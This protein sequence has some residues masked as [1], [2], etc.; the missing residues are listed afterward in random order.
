MT[1]KRPEIDIYTDGACSGNPGPGGYGTILKYG[2][3]VKEISG[4]YRLT[5]NNRME[6]MAVVKGLQELK[7]PCSI[8]LYSDSKYIVDAMNLGWI[9]KWVASGWIKG[10]GLPVKNI[11]LWKSILQLARPHKITWKW[12]KG[13]ASNPFNNRCDSLAVS[14][15]KS[16]NLDEDPGYNSENS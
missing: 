4:G 8:T 5:T 6:L 11:D 1:D 7:K 14:A 15:S 10:D 2:K 12:V 16:S 3:H 13:H 9:N